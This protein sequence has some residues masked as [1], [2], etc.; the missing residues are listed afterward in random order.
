MIV[1][2]DFLI[3]P[4]FVESTLKTVYSHCREQN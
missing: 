4:K 1:I 2:N 3:F